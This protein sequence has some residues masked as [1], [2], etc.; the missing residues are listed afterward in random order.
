MEN[1]PTPCPL[2]GAGKHM[3]KTKALYGHHICKKCYFAFANRRQFAFLIDML[4]WR[5]LMIPISFAIGFTLY[6]LGF[7]KDAVVAFASL[8][9][10][11]LLSVF[12][13]KDA[14]GG[15]SPGK[16]LL[17]VKVLDVRTGQPASIG[18]SFRRNLPLLIPFMPLIVGG[19][20]CSGFRPGD[21]WAHT[22]V[23]WT[24]HASH[25]IFA[26]SVPPPLPHQ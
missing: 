24:R 15:R 12:F 5:V 25:P 2:C 3:K 18:S 1:V 20:L 4:S 11:L 6:F 22:K 26:V 9:G 19:R 17:G 13:C 16:A 23:I 7:E 21:K 10:W 14:F 8:I